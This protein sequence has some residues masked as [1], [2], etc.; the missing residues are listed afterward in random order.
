MK[1]F[2]ILIVSV[3]ALSII[4]FL[5][6]GCKKNSL[7]QI[8]PNLTFIQD[9][10][11]YFNTLLAKEKTLQGGRTS[12]QKGTNQPMTERMKAIN[13]YLNWDEAKEYN[14]DGIKYLIA[15]VKHDAKPFTNKDFEAAKSLIFYEDNL[16]KIHMD[17]V[18]ILSDKGTSLGNNV[19]EIIRTS[20][21]NMY[22]G[23]SKN[24]I[25]VNANVI[26]YNEDYISKSSYKITKGSWSKS[27]VA[28]L[29]ARK[30]GNSHAGRTEAVYE[31]WY[32]I[33]YWYDLAT[34]VIVDW[35][36]L[37]EWVVCISGCDAPPD[38]PL[39][40]DN[41]GSPPG[42]QTDPPVPCPTSLADMKLAFPL[43]DTNNL[44]A[45]VNLVNKYGGAFG[46]D[47]EAKLQY[48]LGQTAAE[49]VSFTNLSK[50]E[51]LN[52][53]TPERL[54]LV[55]KKLFSLTDPN[56]KNPNDYLRD[57]QRLAN[58]V[59]CCHYGNGDEASGDGWAYR[60]RGLMQLTWK[61]NYNDFKN[62]YNSQY[63]SSIDPLSNP[64][65]I[66]TDITLSTISALWFFKQKVLNKI[67]L[68]E[69][70]SVQM[71]TKLIN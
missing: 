23:K 62:F 18:E 65:I 71:V 43:A 21:I 64:D 13:A 59:Y 10:K 57:P 8:N 44:K 37:R 53:T 5:I 38:A 47:T 29:N 1:K 28:L 41:F 14:A 68:N 49:S 40:F 35:V 50:G 22:L 4:L 12:S 31:Q 24:T 25:N 70:T 46:I 15:P 3:F 42:G 2:R 48:F 52:Y 19:Q 17:V 26:F 39:L 60:G 16:G 69:N 7:D 51:N 67:T 33:G 36:I 11:N 45:I 55:Y 20:F 61:D 32:T 27:K 66:S 6:N 54:A 34:G 63:Q 30:V 56:K 9:A 58:L